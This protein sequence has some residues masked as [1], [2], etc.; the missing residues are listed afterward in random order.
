MHLPFIM[1]FILAS[2]A[3]S[4][5]VLATDCKNADI[6]D[7]TTTYKAKSAPTIP[8]GLRWFYCGGLGISLL[9]M[10]KQVCSYRVLVLLTRLDIISM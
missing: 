7:L 10:G 6:Q 1:S 5:I 8:L 2:T 3:L 9:S 4:K